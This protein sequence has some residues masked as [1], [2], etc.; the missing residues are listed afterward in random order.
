M[1]LPFLLAGVLN[2]ET[3]TSG[4]IQ[5]ELDELHR[6]I[7][8]LSQQ[9]ETQDF[10]SQGIAAL[11]APRSFG[12]S[13]TAARV[14]DSDGSV[15]IGGYGEAFYQNRAGSGDN[16]DSLRSVLYVGKRLGDSFVFNSEFEFEHG[17]TSGGGSTS[18]EFAYLDW[19][20][21][22]EF[23]LRAGLLLVPMGIVNE[24]HEPTTFLPT[25]RPEVETRILPS[26]WRGN[27]VGAY[28]DLGPIS[29]T[30]Y[31]MNGFDAA[32]FSAQGLRGGRQKGSRALAEDLAIVVAADYT[33]KPGLVVGG[34]VYVGDSGQGQ[35]AL[36]DA[37]TQI[38]EA[39][40]DYRRGGLRVRGLYAMAELDDVAQL[41]AG[42]GLAGSDSVGEELEGGYVELGYD[43]LAIVSEET[44]QSLSPF[45]RYEMFDTQAAVPAGFTSDVANDETIVTFG[46]SYQPTSSVVFKLDYE[47]RDRGIDRWHASV[48]YVF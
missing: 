37:G 2:G 39:H 20:M 9:L 18:A 31:I 14:Y 22:P 25:Q 21:R 5:A 23:N 7:D 36:G 17:G 46:L 42:L 43:V 13:P 3:P 11:D 4:D 35:S 8:L 33:E 32:G 29:Y 47:D 1:I 28:G 40:V 44:R 38:A 16:A 34:S 19:L 12:V 6:R 45:V 10:A 26:T 15:S 27:G 48:G 30:T 41:N 24:M